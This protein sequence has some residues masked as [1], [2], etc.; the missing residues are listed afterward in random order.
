MIHE[1]KSEPPFADPADLLPNFP[2][3]F[4][5]GTP[6][7]DCSNKHL[8]VSDT[9]LNHMLHSLSPVAGTPQANSELDPRLYSILN[10]QQI[11]LLKRFELY[12]KSP[13]TD[14][15]RERSMLSL[16]KETPPASDRVVAHKHVRDFTD[17]SSEFEIL[18]RA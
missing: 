1:N 18:A 12:Q 2:Q 9:S 6:Y 17:F 15:A 14:F 4:S 10:P 8:P 11:S 5:A 7:S 3:H 13:N 16:Y